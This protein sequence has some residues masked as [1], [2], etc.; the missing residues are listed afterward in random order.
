M[1]W[2]GGKRAKNVDSTRSS[3]EVT[4]LPDGMPAYYHYHDAKMDS[5]SIPAPPQYRSSP[6]SLSSGAAAASGLITIDSTMMIIGL[7]ILALFI[8]NMGLVIYFFATRG[9]SR[10]AEAAPPSTK[11]QHTPQVRY[12]LPT[13]NANAMAQYGNVKPPEQDMLRPRDFQSFQP[14]SMSRGRS[15]G[16]SRSGS[17][18]SLKGMAETME[19]AQC[20]AEERN[21]EVRNMT[22]QQ[23]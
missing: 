19:E 12:T 1:K 18:L 22:P 13:P 6:A 9:T 21:E 5:H 20:F 4:S 8:V 16:M 17:S 10:H 23:I 2:F 15:R 14:P 3:Y 11:E 7:V